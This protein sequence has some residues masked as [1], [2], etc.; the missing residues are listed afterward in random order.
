M[1]SVH[2]FHCTVCKR[3]DFTSS[4]GFHK[5]Q[6]SHFAPHLDFLRFS[7]DLEDEP[8]DT[9]HQPDE[10]LEADIEE[11]YGKLTIEDMSP[12]RFHTPRNSEPPSEPSQ[13]PRQPSPEQLKETITHPILTVL[14]TPCDEFGKPLLPNT[15]PP[16]ST[17]RSQDDWFPH[18]DRVAFETAELLYQRNRM[19]MAQIDVLMAL[20]QASLLQ[21]FDPAVDDEPA[22]PPFANHKELLATIDATDLADVAWESLQFEYDGQLPSGGVPEWMTKKYEVWFR[23][24]RKLVQNML[25]NPNFDGEFD[26]APYQRFAGKDGQEYQ[27]FMSGKWA[28]A[29]SDEIG[30]DPKM[31]GS[32][33]VPIIL[34]SDKT[35]VS[36]AT[37]QTEYYPL[38][39]SIGNVKNHVR[40]A[41][42]EAVVLLGFLSIPKISPSLLHSSLAAIL[43]SLKP[44]MTKPD[45]T[46][47]PDGHFRWVIY[48]IGP[49]IADYLEQFPIAC[50]VPGWCPRCLAFPSNLDVPA[51]VRTKQ[52]RL[53]ACQCF[54]LTEVWDHYRIVGDIV[55]FTDHFPRAEINQ[56]IA[57]DLLHQL[58]KGVFKD[59]LV[60][61]T[62]EYILQ[63]NGKA[64]GQKI[65][66]EIDPRIT[67]T[68]AFPGLRWFP[69]GPGFK[70]WTGDDSK[71][72]MKVYIP[73]IEGLVPQDIVRAFTTYLDFCYLARR[74]S[75]TSRD[76]LRLDQALG[77]FH[78]Y[79]QIFQEVGVREGEAIS[80]P[81][82]HA[83]IPRPNKVK[84]SVFSDPPRPRSTHPILRPSPKNCHSLVVQ[85]PFHPILRDLP[86]N[87]HSTRA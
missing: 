42:R 15:S 20:W 5:H 62:M 37:G 24:P 51:S 75:L 27:D 70:Q 21:S 71:A 47:C 33:F 77:R 49:Y 35:M 82:Q 23:D 4:G 56:L 32:M 55:P 9:S 18:G 57:P 80:L 83:M 87:L 16:P 65:L 74:A 38:Y 84:D 30:L 43:L 63:E 76:L 44:F 11:Q 85:D 54:G 64:V 69:Q 78:E 58:I 14:A 86:S 67:L 26:Y 50:V 46:R 79:H 45:V 1:P 25:K 19:P 6:N 10:T 22:S 8:Q 29:Q 41:H 73:A 31:H 36:V 66:D 28:W 2:R 60:E 40:R 68:P 3:T 34:G 12:S 7:P 17:T 52:H 61:W 39:L 72:L 53:L 13:S 48:G 81:R 59:H